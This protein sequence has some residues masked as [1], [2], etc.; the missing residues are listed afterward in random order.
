M[1][2]NKSKMVKKGVK[3]EASQRLADI[4]LE[5][6]KKSISLIESV[7]NLT[8]KLDSAVEEIKKSNAEVNKSVTR[9]L[10]LFEEASKHVTEVES[11]EEK[12]TSLSSKLATLL[13]QNKNIARGL[14]LLEKYIRGRTK[15][16]GSM[17]PQSMSDYGGL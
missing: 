6:Q 7:N 15:L 14:I 2:Y 5:L 9:I 3:K 17:E 10:S 16:E 8:K 13:E 11:A 1:F 12:I 4:N